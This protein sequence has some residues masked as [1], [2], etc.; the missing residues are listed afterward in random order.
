MLKVA[1]SKNLE[2]RF[3]AYLIGRLAAEGA[4]I[5]AHKTLIFEAAIEAANELVRQQPAEAEI[6]KRCALLAERILDELRRKIDLAIKPSGPN[7][8]SLNLRPQH[9]EELQSIVSVA[10]KALTIANMRSLGVCSIEATCECGRQMVV[11]F[12][13]LPGSIEVSALRHQLRCVEC[14]GRPNDV[15]PNWLEY[16]RPGMGRKGVN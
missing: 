3:A 8:V 2:V 13:G 7:I 4:C 9:L 10:A 12:T 11:D 14:G 16:L 15:R 6:E 5:G 1:S